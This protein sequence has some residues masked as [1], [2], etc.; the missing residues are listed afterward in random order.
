MCLSVALHDTVVF[1]KVRGSQF[2]S[3][4]ESLKIGLICQK[5]CHVGMGLHRWN[6][7]IQEF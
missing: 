6:D 7:E 5:F 4:I 3:V 1:S 2:C